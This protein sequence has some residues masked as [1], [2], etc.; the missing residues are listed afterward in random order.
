MKK[1]QLLGLGFVCLGTMIAASAYWN[2]QDLDSPP[3]CRKETCINKDAANEKC[4]H[5]A[6][7]LSSYRSSTT[8]VE[9]RYSKKCDASWSRASAPPRSELYVRDSSGTEYGRY[10]ITFDTKA[11]DH[12]GDMGAGKFLVACVRLPN[13]KESICTE[14]P[15]K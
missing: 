10:T 13:I 6:K 15:T 14:N 12:F 9:L 11:G 8:N 2:Y 1:Q 5:D 3:F 7:T 4:D